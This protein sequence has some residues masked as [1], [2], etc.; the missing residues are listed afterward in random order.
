MTADGGPPA[1]VERPPTGGV[2][3]GGR[4]VPATAILR[5][6]LLVWGLG[7][8]ALGD[9]RGWLLLALQPLAI[10]VVVG[11]AVLLIDSTRWIVVFPCLALLVVA[12]LGQAIHAHQLA[13]RHGAPGGGEM[14]IVWVLPVIMAI[15]TAFWLFGGDHGSPAAT[16][17]EYVSAWHG[18]RVSD[19]TGLFAEPP[20]DEQL[21]IVWRGHEEYVRRQVQAAAARFGPMSGLDPDDPLAGLRYL[22]MTE[23][24]SADSALVAVDIIRRQ[25]V[26][27]TL[28]GLIPTATQETVLVERAGLIRLHALPAP[29][30]AWLPAGQPPPR[31]WRIDEVRLPL[32]EPAGGG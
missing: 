21:A 22:E 25:R 28:F 15:M 27:T 2:E 14:Q 19:A 29:L 7:H 11:L 12:W 5:R 18:G 1:L 30:P 10:A 32:G 23:E 16:L 4:L 20:T 9:R 17:Q 24:R 31:V 26:E 6:A 13:L 3:Q 8:L